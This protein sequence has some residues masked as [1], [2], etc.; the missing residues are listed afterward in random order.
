M[1][2]PT[3]L[4]VTPNSG[5]T[6]PAQT[7]VTV[8]GTDFVSVVYVKFGTQH[9]T[10]LNVSSSATLTVTAPSGPMASTVDVRV[11]T[12]AGTSPTGPQAKFTYVGGRPPMP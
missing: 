1:P 5:P 4:S 3:V 12:P 6:A 8:T 7:N 10:N 2:A 9:G 11:T